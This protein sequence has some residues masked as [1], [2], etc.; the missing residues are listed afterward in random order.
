MKKLVILLFLL[1]SVGS[2]QVVVPPVCF[3]YLTNIST[4][5]VGTN[6]YS[7]TNADFNIDGFQDLAVANYSSNN[8]SVL[9]GFG[10]STFSSAVNYPVGTNPCSL[11]NADFNNDGKLD[12][13][14][15]NR[16]SNNVSI[17]FATSPGS[18]ST[19]VNYPVGTAPN[20]VFVADLNNDGNKDLV[21]ANYNSNNISVLLGSPTGTFSAATNFNVGTNPHSVTSADLNNDGNMDIIVTNIVSNNAYVFLG[22][23]S[24]NFPS[25][26]IFLNGFGL[27][28]YGPLVTTD[29]NNDTKLDIITANGNGNVGLSIFLGNGTGGFSFFNSILT[30]GSVRGLLIKDF[31]GDAN[32]DI[33]TVNSNNCIG[34]LFGDGAGNLTLNSYYYSGPN[35]QGFTSTDVNGDGKLDFA[36]TNTTSTTCNVSIVLG[37]GIG[38]FATVQPFNPN[39]GNF[40]GICRGDFNNDGNLDIATAE[41]SGDKIAVHLGTGTGSFGAAITHNWTMTAGDIISADFNNDGKLDIGTCG[42]TSWTNSVTLLLG[43]GTG[44]FSINF[45]GTGMGNDPIALTAG[46]FN[47]DGNK[48]VAT[49]NFSGNTISIFLGTGTGSLSNATNYVASSGQRSIKNADFNGDGFLDL[50]VACFNHA[51]VYMGN[52][53]GTFMPFVSYPVGLS[54]FS[55]V[56]GDFNGDGSVDIATAN[57]YSDNV[58][59]LKGSPTGTFSSLGNYTTAPS[60]EALH[61]GDLNGDG[62]LDLVAGNSSKVNILLGHGT[63]FF[64]QALSYDIGYGASAITSGDFNGDS[65]Q[66]LAMVDPSV[67]KV[68]MNGNAPSISVSGPS[69]TCS[70][71]PI[72][73]TASGSNYYNWSTGATTSTVSVAPMTNTVYTVYGSNSAGCAVPV[74]KTV[75]VITSPTITVNNGAICVGNS[76]TIVPGGAASY[77]ISGGSPIVTPS[78]TTSYT[79]SGTNTLGCTSM[80]IC[81][82]TVNPL[83]TITVSNGTIC[84]SQS[85]TMNPIGASTYTYSSGIP[86][87]TPT[88]SSSYSITGTSV[89]GCVSQTPAVCNVS[90]SATPAPTI[91][92]NSGVICPGNSFTMTPSGALSYTFSSGPI[93]SPT[94]TT[95]YSITGTDAYG[96]IATLPAI[97]NVTVNTFSVS[98]SNGTICVGNSFTINPTGA[99]TYTISGGNAVVSPTAVTSYSIVGTSSYGCLSTNTAV[100]VVNVNP[101][102]TISILP[103]GSVTIC[104]GDLVNLIALGANTF[105]WNTNQTV[106]SIFVNP[107]ITTSYTVTGTSSATGCKGSSVTTVSVN[108]SPTLSIAPSN[109]VACNGQTISLT[110]SGASSYSWNTGPITTTIVVTPSVNTN[111]TVVGTSGS[112]TNQAIQSISINPSPTISVNSGSMC[113]G[114]LFSIIPSGASTYTIQGGSAVV[115]PSVSSSFT[116]IGT[117]VLG[118]ISNSFATSNITVS[119]SPTLSVNSGAICFGDSFTMTPSGANSYTFLP[120]GPIV[121]PTATISYSVIGSSSI[122]CLSTNTAISNVTVNPLPIIT[123]SIT[124]SMICLGNTVTV[125]GGGATTYTWTGNIM[126]GISFTPSVS[127]SYTVTGTN[128]LTGCTGTNTSIQSVTVNP[129]PTITASSSSSLLCVGQTATL[130]SSGANSYSWAP[131]ATGSIIVISPSIT[132]TYTV[133]GTDANGCSNFTSITQSVSACTSLGSYYKPTEIN[134]FPNPTSGII[135]IQANAG[136]RIAVYDVHGKIIFLKIMTGDKEELNLSESSNGLYFVNIIENDRFLT[137]KV[138][139][140]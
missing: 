23:G 130:T 56:T 99:S 14:T 19:A 102:P 61:T 59:I 54:P 75:S 126:D 89:F 76:Y 60:P 38:S 44:S 18:F 71:S 45:F 96:C 123:S 8:V 137:F 65:K 15:A 24:G 47:G 58:T 2:G 131:S 122:G 3:N 140:E 77:T 121:S 13:V 9:A 41:D 90:V 11:K 80:T 21:T 95:S 98:V 55:V 39:Y 36:I 107:S 5:S 17:L 42:Y 50:V 28:F 6:P 92:V 125:Y 83:P 81:T 84:N 57:Y 108:P 25:S 115:S 53:N 10:N 70:G 82:V 128:T 104:S 136:S 114:S 34:V 124:N 119:P 31:N 62:K 22:N 103:G 133:Y 85:F 113:S 26:T 117:S 66:D 101:N 106:N 120:S 4:G 132:S 69:I 43:N 63:G 29:I 111:Y 118:C 110:A 78:V 30:A 40:Q 20:C 33:A 97:S 88:I 93:V 127:S 138:I 64:D 116:V 7:I 109:T 32:T 139:K 129:N 37:T 16:G 135:T 1:S 134:V 105:T 91:T 27:N 35:P 87:V 94:I 49:S 12:L 52:G 72:I 46:D 100:A 79:V 51:I 112:C 73:L 74:S 68:F 86:V 67:T 48:D